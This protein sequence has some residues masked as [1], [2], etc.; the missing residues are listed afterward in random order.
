MT[1]GLTLVDC[2][3]KA[4]DVLAALHAGLHALGHELSPMCGGS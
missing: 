3:W 2:G 4:D 1:S